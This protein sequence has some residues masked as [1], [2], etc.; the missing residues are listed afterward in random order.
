LDLQTKLS[1]VNLHKR[2]S[3]A[4]RQSIMMNQR[5]KKT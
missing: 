3:F 5:A 2:E 1:L 4:L